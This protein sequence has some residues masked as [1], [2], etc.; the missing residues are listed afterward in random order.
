M[1]LTICFWFGIACCDPC[2]SCAGVVFQLVQHIV[3]KWFVFAAHFAC[4]CL[5]CM[6]KDFLCGAML[7]HIGDTGLMSLTERDLGWSMR[8]IAFLNV[9]DTIGGVDRW[10]CCEAFNFFSL[11][12]LFSRA[13]ALDKLLFS[14][15][16]FTYHLDT[17]FW[18]IA[19]LTSPKTH[20][21]QLTCRWDINWSTTLSLF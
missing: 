13:W 21:V 8:L 7:V 2:L 11:C 14:F 20:S 12:S 16:S 4:F 3:A 18:M 1:W 17:H 15:R 10:L 6:G 5:C 9:F 19:N